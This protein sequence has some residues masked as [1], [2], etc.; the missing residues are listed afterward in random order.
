[1]KNTFDEQHYKK[2]LARHITGVAIVTSSHQ[3]VNRGMTCNAFCSISL[4]PPILLVSLS[5][6]G[7]TAQLIQQS[8]VFALNILSSEQKELA[9]KF[10]IKPQADVDRF[11][12]VDWKVQE[13]GSPVFLHSQC[14]FDCRVTQ[15][16]IVGDHLLFFGEVAD[17]HYDS[18]KNPLIYYRSHLLQLEDWSA[19]NPPAKK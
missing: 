18:H 6:N 1:M 7:R 15:S 16:L 17:F 11:E 19:L 10:A 2:A 9:E 3:D 14:Y 12:G 5:K 4:T 13:T 8:Q